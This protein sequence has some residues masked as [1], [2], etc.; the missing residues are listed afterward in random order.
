MPIG[1]FQ[2]YLR[3]SSNYESYMGKLVASFNP[4]T[5]S[6][7]MC[8]TLLSVSWDGCLFDCDFHQALNLP[9]LPGL[10]Q[11]IG[12]FDLQTLATT[13]HPPG[14]TLLRLHRGQRL[15]LR[16]E[17]G[18]G[19]MNSERRAVEQ[20]LPSPPLKLPSNPIKVVRRGSQPQAVAMV[21]VPTYINFEL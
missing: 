12:E 2:D 10:P 1:R 3:R 11:T 15:L 21:R 4:A 13:P 5:V 16:R 8:R 19:R 20:L 17:F 6:G 9:L 7:L 18:G 14:R